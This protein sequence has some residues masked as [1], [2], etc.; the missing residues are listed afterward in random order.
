MKK[1]KKVYL[2]LFILVVLVIIA[3]V[4]KKTGFNKESK[5]KVAIEKVK[6]KNITEIVSANGKIEPEKEIKI[7]PYIS[8]EVVELGVIEGEYVKKGDF[9]AKID[10]EIYKSN[11]E[12]IQANLNRQKAGMANARARLA[13]VQAQYLKAKKDYERQLKLYNQEVI[14]EAEIENYKSQY[15][16]AQAN[17]N[18]ANENLKASEYDIKSMQAS[19]KE[20]RE[21]LS[22]T[23]LF[24]PSEGTIS[25][26]NIEVGERVTGAS[27]FS[28]GTE[29]MRIANLEKM[30]V[31][32]SVNENDII[33]IHLQDTVLIEVDAYFNRKFK[34]IV[35]EIATSASTSGQLS[36]DQVTNF[37]VKVRILPS[38]YADLM[39]KEGANKSPFRPGM[40]AS[41]DIQ[42]NTQYDTPSV[43]IQA[44]VAKTDTTSSTDKL[45]EYVFVEENGLAI[46]KMVETGIQDNEY[47]QIKKG[48]DGDEKVIYAPYR[49]VSRHLKDSVKVT[50]VA[51]DELLQKN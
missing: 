38:S 33:K 12:R 41:V 24:A 10:P 29:L 51:K 8:G 45:S 14:S 22:R 37:D 17:V 32:V 39:T 35:T 47:I 48:L 21:N 2:L 25:R 11:F 43:L 15:D 19:L 26:L 30:E 50:V 3:L 20:A 1:R 49:V 18:A 46:K 28:A 36:A 5:Y 34:G 27:Q 23:S 6:K 42:T 31:N 9:L 7:T 13:Q 40:S 16:V 44:V 4:T